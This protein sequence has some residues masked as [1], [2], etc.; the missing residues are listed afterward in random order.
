[1]PRFS[2]NSSFLGVLSGGGVASTRCSCPHKKVRP[3][4]SCIT[5]AI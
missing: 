4:L 1:L 5:L 2:Q 3:H